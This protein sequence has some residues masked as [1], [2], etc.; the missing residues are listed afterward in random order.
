MQIIKGPI[1]TKARKQ[2]Q[3]NFCL[4]KIEKGDLYLKSVCKGDYIYSWKVHR[5]CDK[6]AEKLGIYDFYDEGATADDFIETVKQEY[7]GIIYNHPN[8]INRDIDL[9]PLDFQSQLKLV[10]SYHDIGT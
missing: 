3:C 10:V 9:T 7:N 8:K 5:H 6:V 1:E 4:G 2:H